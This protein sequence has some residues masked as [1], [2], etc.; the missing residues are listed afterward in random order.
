MIEMFRVTQPADINAVVLLA[1]EIWEEHYVP[2]IGREQVDYM[3]DKFQS[4][5]AIAQQ[6]EN[7]YE[8]YLA[9]N[10]PQRAGYFALVPDPAAFKTLLSKLYVRQTQRGHGTG[11]AIMAFVEQ[12][13]LEL[14]VRELWLTVNRH[15]KDAIAFYQSMGFTKS[16]RV[17]QDI[18]NGFVMD[19][20]KMVKSV[21][22][23]APP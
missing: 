14:G 13:C 7:G 18:G 8:Y 17:V 22:S 1:R 23:P 20:Y 12:R 11:K 16:E 6:M 21:G 19:D 15:N 9:M 2:I 10:G 3:L 4:A 5:P